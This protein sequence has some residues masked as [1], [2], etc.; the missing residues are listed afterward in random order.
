M[1]VQGL[2]AIAEVLVRELHFPLSQVFNP[3]PPLRA[4]I[5]LLLGDVGSEQESLL[6]P[7]FGGGKV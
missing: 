3:M 6:R 5:Q 4:E 2:V 1:L 7:R